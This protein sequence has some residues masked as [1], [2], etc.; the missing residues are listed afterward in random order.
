MQNPKPNLPAINKIESLVKVCPTIGEFCLKRN[1]IET[2]K[3][4][5]HIKTALEA[6]E[7][8][9]YTL[10]EI[11]K[12]YNQ[13]SVELYIEIWLEN[14]N[15]SV[16]FRRKM[17]P[18]QISEIAYFIYDDF[19]YFN[20]AELNLIFLKI[21]KGEFGEFYEGID[22]TKIMECFRKYNMERIKAIERKETPIISEPMTT[23]V[24]NL[25]KLLV[26]NPD[27]CPSYMK[28]VDSVKVT[29]LNKN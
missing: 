4:Y 22:C 3:K 7:S 29:P 24:S 21:K 13:N 28:L 14:L 12:A 15:D 6:I 8:N 1:P 16:N 27:K 5:R 18:F 26:S 11:K 19:F 17:E 23:K 2:F 20:I 25:H 9:A 10:V